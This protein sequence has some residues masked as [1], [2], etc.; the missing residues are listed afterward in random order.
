[1]DAFSYLSVLLSIVL[2]LGLTQLL[3]ALG[4]LLG[5]RDRVRFYWLP[6]LW[7]AV[8]FVV[9]VQVWWTSFGLRQRPAWSFLDFLIVLTQTATLYLMAAL[10]LPE[11]VEGE[12]VDLATHYEKHHRW[13]FG[14]FLATLIV[15][16]AKDVV[17]S[18]SLPT[19]TN[20]AFHVV[21][22]TACVVALLV[23]SRRAHETIGVVC[24]V[25]IA[26]YIGLL[27]A[28]LQ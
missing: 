25:A 10:L 26:A 14:F 24:A 12:T 6:L 21:F 22:G 23:D 16:I 7:T 4:R 13:F 8:L 27:F 3:S 20:L 18:G 2:G 1:M 5:H 9:Y 19:A 17:L 11:Q 15:S 28:H